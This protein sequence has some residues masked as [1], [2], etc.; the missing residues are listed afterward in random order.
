LY[1][2]WLNFGVANE[3]STVSNSVTGGGAMSNVGAGNNTTFPN[4]TTRI[5]YGPD[6][7]TYIV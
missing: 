6:G 5:A 2:P 7:K 1:S 3:R 4:R